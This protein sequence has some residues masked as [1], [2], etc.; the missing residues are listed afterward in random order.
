MTTFTQGEFI[1]FLIKGDL[2]CG[3]RLREL[4]TLKGHVESVVKLKGLDIDT[5]QQHYTV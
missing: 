1:W 3:F 5:I 4:H 2:N